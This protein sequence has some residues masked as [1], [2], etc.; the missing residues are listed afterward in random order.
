MAKS[1]VK[2]QKRYSLFEFHREHG[3]EAQY[4]KTLFCQRF[5]MPLHL[6]GQL[7]LTTKTPSFHSA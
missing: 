1:K 3:T 2:F 4:E 7:D 5:T 6:H